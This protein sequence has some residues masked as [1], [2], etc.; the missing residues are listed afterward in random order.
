MRSFYLSMESPV[1]RITL[2]SNETHLKAVTFSD[3]EVDESDDLPGILQ[4]TADQLKEYFS[5]TRHA[6][7]LPID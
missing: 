1:G 7:D 5:G 4:K 6:F 2:I 3:E